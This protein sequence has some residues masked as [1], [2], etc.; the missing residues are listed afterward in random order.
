MNH[1]YRSHDFRLPR[2]LRYWIKD[3]SPTERDTWHWFLDRTNNQLYERVNDGFYIHKPTT[4]R[5][6]EFYYDCVPSAI[7]PDS[8]RYA[9][10]SLE[11]TIIKLINTNSNCIQPPPSDTPQFQLHRTSILRFLKDKLPP[12]ATQRIGATP[13][14]DK[15]LEDLQEGHAILGSDGSNFPLLLKAG[16]SW[17]ISNKDHSQFV[18]GGGAIPGDPYDY[19]SYR[20]EIAGMVAS[21][22]ALHILI[23]HLPYHAPQ[24]TIICDNES[25]LTN[26]QPSPRKLKPKW[27]HCDLVSILRQIWDSSPCSPVPLHVYGHQ[28]NRYG[29]PTV[30]EHI[31]MHMD[32]RAKA[33][34]LSFVPINDHGNLWNSKG[35]GSVKLQGKLIGGAYKKNIYDSICHSKYITYLSHK[36]LHDEEVMTDEIAWPVFRK[37]RKST[38]HH[39]R[40]FITK[41]LIGHLPTGDIMKKRQQRIHANCPHCSCTNETLLHMVLCPSPTVQ[42]F[43]ATTLQDL[44]MWLEEQQTEPHLATYLV[45]GLSSWLLDPYGEELTLEQFPPHLHAT[46]HSHHQLGWFALLVGFIHPNIIH[47]QQKHLTSLQYRTTGA[48]WASRLI[49]YLWRALYELWLLR[50]NTL[51]EKTIHD[52]NGQAHLDFSISVEHHLGPLGLPSQFNPYFNISLDELLAKNITAKIRWFRL[53]RQAREVREIT[54]RDAFQTNIT[55]RR[56]VHLPTTS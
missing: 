46:F 35:F 12:W 13:N 29:P 50:N 40:I 49:R 19:D 15:L 27:R 47:L 42:N 32:R 3:T 37:A 33:C 6:K 34:A 22:A 55:L 54:I 25:A 8:V 53:I 26:L 31:N 44:H 51:H 30:Q 36:W 43:W 39:M 48:T 52:N 56:W 10:V 1:I 9:S 14:I 41:W 38:Q 17:C 23:P 45:L 21:S 7:L 24:Y 5:S 28:E 2:S 11:P 20:S 18:C 16:C 4:R